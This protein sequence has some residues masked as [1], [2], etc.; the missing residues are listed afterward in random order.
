[1]FLT[2]SN[3]NLQAFHWMDADNSGRV[4][5]SEIIRALEMWNIPMAEADV[6]KIMARCDTDGSGEIDYQ[7]FTDN[8]ARFLQFL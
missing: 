8:M 2:P 5:K 7:E 6:D 3:P 1:M 4:S